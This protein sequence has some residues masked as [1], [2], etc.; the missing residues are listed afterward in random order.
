MPDTAADPVA[1]LKV[2]DPARARLELVLRN[3]EGLGDIP[4]LVAN[5][6]IGKGDILRDRGGGQPINELALDFWELGRS[7]FRDLELFLGWNV[8][9][10]LFVLQDFADGT[11]L[12]TVFDRDVFLSSGGVLLVVQADLLAVDIK[13]TLLFMFS[14]DGSRVNLGLGL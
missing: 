2:F 7:V 13:K 9:P 11:P 8:H 4:G 14:E 12:D 1:M 10:L 5:Q 6:R 3:P